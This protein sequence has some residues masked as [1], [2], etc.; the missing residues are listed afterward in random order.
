MSGRN[1]VHST[2]GVN[3]TEDLAQLLVQHPG[4]IPVLRVTQHN[5]PSDEKFTRNG[6]VRTVY[7]AIKN[8]PF[9]LSLSLTNNLIFNQL[10]DLNHFTLDVR[11]IYETDSSSEKEVDFVKAKPVEFK[12]TNN[13]RADQTVLEARIKVLTSHHEDMFFR[14]KIV[15]LDPKTGREF[16]PSIYCYSE[17]LKVISKPEQIKKKKPNKKR[18]LTD[19]LVETVTRI[20]RQ[21]TDQQK[22]I[23]KLLTQQQAAVN[24]SFQFQSQERVKPISSGN[25]INFNWEAVPPQQPAPKEPSTDTINDFESAFATFISSYNALSNE[26]KP[27]KIRKIIRTSSTR[28]TERLSEMIDLFTSEGLQQ[29]IGS[30]VRP[31]SFSTYSCSCASCPHKQEL[32]RIDDFYKDFLS[33]PLSL[34][35]DLS[36]TTS[37]NL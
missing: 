32:V 16:T 15:A 22:L 12:Q 37:I 24:A 11:L 13:D 28:D 9:Q 10:V 4:H 19:M 25:E 20:E 27:E 34:A 26:E 1:V 35:A 36:L 18:T 29:D 21:Q 17:P 2:S 23:E 5:T 30:E 7:V 3:R 6:I 31:H 8:T 33:S 14:A